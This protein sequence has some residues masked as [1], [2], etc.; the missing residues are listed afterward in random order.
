MVDITM[1]G[2]GTRASKA[3]PN[4]LVQP[5]RMKPRAAD[6]ER[7]VA[8]LALRSEA[9]VVDSSGPPDRLT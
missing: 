7:Y 4:P 1:H 3:T 8:G 6:Q 2:G 9:M 5:M